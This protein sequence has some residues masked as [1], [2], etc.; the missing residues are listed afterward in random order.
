MP[1][2][3]KALQ[4]GQS[5]DRPKLARMWGYRS[6][7]AISRGVVTP[8]QTKYIVLFA[9]K[10]KQ[11][12]PIQRRIRPRDLP[13][14]RIGPIMFGK[15]PRNTNYRRHVCNGIGV[16]RPRR[17]FRRRI[18]SAQEL[19][20][21]KAAGTPAISARIKPEAENGPVTLPVRTLWVLVS[22]RMK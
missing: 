20:W 2:S 7:N 11:E 15:D 13:Q 19:G 10:E 16:P 9:T 18:A 17:R 12:A 8:A 6:F 21:Y 3:F 22:S 14:R 5:Y 1:V 4:T